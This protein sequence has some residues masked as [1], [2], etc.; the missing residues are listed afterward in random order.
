MTNVYYS[1]INIKPSYEDEFG[2]EIEINHQSQHQQKAR[3]GQQEARRKWGN[4]GTIEKY[5]ETGEKNMGKQ[6][7]FLVHWETALWSLKWAIEIY[8]SYLKVYLCV[9]VSRKVFESVILD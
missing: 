8:M 9:Y 6:G 7:D 5:G 1:G 3:T 2:A 4:R